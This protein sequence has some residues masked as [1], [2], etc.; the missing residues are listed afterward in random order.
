VRRLDREQQR[1]AGAWHEVREAAR[2][3]DLEAQ[4]PH[5]VRE[6]EWRVSGYLLDSSNPNPGPPFSSVSRCDLELPLA[7][8][9][10]LARPSAAEARL[11]D[12]TEKRPP[13][14]GQRIE[15]THA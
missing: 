7:C 9:G 15:P 13:H 3:E 8:L 5:H 12:P 10:R 11:G 4:P 2:Q 6:L 14:L 1:R